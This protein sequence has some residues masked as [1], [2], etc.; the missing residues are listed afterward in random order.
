MDLDEDAVAAAQL[1]ARACAGDSE[2][3]GRLTAPHRHELLIHCYRM[4]GSMQDAEDALQ[5][6]L[7]AAWQALAGF[8]LRSSLRTWLYTIATHRCL[9]ARRATRRRPPKGW[10]VPG[11]QPPMPSR[12]GEV[13]WLE[14]LPDEL[15]ARGVG[16]SPGPAR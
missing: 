6:T 1:L 10:D 14:P 11:V 7:L 2:A 13:V 16:L 4:L 5:E 9:N 12:L 3:F 15:V 8:E